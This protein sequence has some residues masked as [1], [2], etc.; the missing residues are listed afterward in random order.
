MKDKY[1]VGWFLYGLPYYSKGGRRFATV[2]EAQNAAAEADASQDW[3]L[4]SHT[5]VDAAT[6]KT[7]N[8]IRATE[9]NYKDSHAEV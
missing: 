4:L 7:L 1:C 3:T 5:V 9:V 8:G 6:K 2:E